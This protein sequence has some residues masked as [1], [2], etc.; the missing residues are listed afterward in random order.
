MEVLQLLVLIALYAV[1][2]YIANATPILIHGTKPLD[3]GKSLGKERVLGKGKSILGTLAG[4]CCGSLAG[5]LVLLAFSETIVPLIQNYFAL[6][7]LLAA[8]A[9][10]GDL[11]KSFLKR[12]IGIKS[13]QRWLIA[14]QWDFVLG[15]FAL[16][17]VARAPEVEVFVIILLATL[18]IH[19]AT[20]FAA[21]KLK[22]KSVPW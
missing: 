22:L 10:F 12:R 8:G 14:D 7:I 9:I 6:A 5:L 13:G 2:M 4:I 3:F 18:F 21:F 11:V 19:V 17:L 20:N 15:A 16:S 1:P